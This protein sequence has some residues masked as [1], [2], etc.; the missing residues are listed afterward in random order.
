MSALEQWHDEIRRGE[1]TRDKPLDA[2]WVAAG[3]EIADEQFDL[4]YLAP[5]RAR[6]AFIK[7][8]GKPHRSPRPAKWE[9]DLALMAEYDDGA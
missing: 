3:R 2:L 8:R 7:D 1:R 5:A 9:R 6:L 4:E